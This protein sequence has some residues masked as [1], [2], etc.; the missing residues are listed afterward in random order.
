M[1]K[2]P[3]H[4][5]VPGFTFSATLAGIKKKTGFDLGLILSDAPC[6]VAGVFTRNSV[7]AAPV[8]NCTAKV[9]RGVAQ[10]VLV[11]SGNANA[12][13]G[14]QGLQSTKLTCA[15]LADVLGIKENH[16]LP[17]STGVIGSPLPHDTIIA[18]LPELTNNAAP[19]NAPSFSESI[20]TTDTCTKTIAVREKINGRCVHVL[21]MAK[22]SG[23]IMP[24]MAT[25]LAFIVTDADVDKTL[26][27]SL[28]REETE[29]SFNRICVDGD[30]STNDTVLLMA[31]GRSGITVTLKSKALAPFRAMLRKVMQ[32][33]AL[34][35]VKD[36]EGATKLLRIN[37]SGA[38]TTADAKKAGLQVARSCLVKT[39]FFG[40][41]YNWGRIIAAL[42]Q[43]GAAC[44]PEKISI[45][46][47]TIPTVCNGQGIPENRARLVN[48]M[49]QKEI[50]LDINLHNG[51][52]KCGVITCDL[53]YD[54]VKI[55]A[56]YTT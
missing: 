2:Y 21:G 44:R 26:L 49:K 37:V 36:G 23:M 34:M 27:A 20:L 30:M 33:L 10:A 17:C 25:M 52:K 4:R 29:M 19:G 56:D 18:A 32:E 48:V 6:P 11:N 39:A 1:K 53:S 54:Y 38:K 43:S 42:G 15:S 50:T 28:L 5:G 40:E 22:G 51:R 41:D 45:H 9:K 13:T 31:G 8:I 14:T 16:I 24:D 35:I 47:N 3:A 12:C 55:N 7:K 46:F